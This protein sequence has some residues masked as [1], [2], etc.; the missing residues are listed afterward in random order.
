ML[1]FKQLFTFSEAHCSI[2]VN[3]VTSS[4]VTVLA[5]VVMLSV[6]ILSVELPTCGTSCVTNQVFK[7]QIGS[8]YVRYLQRQG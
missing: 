5:S 3:V 4:I 6:I 7:C 1:I 2:A 8:G